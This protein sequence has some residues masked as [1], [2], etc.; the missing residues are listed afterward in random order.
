MVVEIRERDGK[1]HGSAADD[2]AGT[3]SGALVNACPGPVW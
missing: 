3:Y 2:G 1:W